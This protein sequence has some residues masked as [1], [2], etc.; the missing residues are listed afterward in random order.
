MSTT[1][2]IYSCVLDNHE[3]ETESN[4]VISGELI[5]N[6]KNTNESISLEVTPDYQQVEII[7]NRTPSCTM[8]H[9]N[10]INDVTAWIENGTLHAVNRVA[11]FIIDR[12]IEA[13]DKNEKRWLHIHKVG[14]RWM[15][16]YLDRDEEPLYGSRIFKLQ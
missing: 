12:F 10:D 11:H 16:K 6:I 2:Q 1:T 5:V 14:L 7:T 4:P 9:V 13:F 15:V 3:I 8:Y